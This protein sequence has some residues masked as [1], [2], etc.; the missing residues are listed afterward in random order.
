M[1]TQMQPLLE[2]EVS[3][4]TDMMPQWQVILFNDEEHSYDYVIELLMGIFG[5]DF[6]KSVQLTKQI[7]QEGQAIV[8]TTSRERAELKQDQV[9]SKGRDVRMGSKSTGPLKCEITPA[10]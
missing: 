3:N 6:D 2:P 5:H 1:N 10:E 4:K 9:K 7:D 8:D